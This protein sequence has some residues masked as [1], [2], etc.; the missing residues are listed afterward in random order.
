MMGCN[1][2]A[3]A[4]DYRGPRSFAGADRAR[5]EK[6]L[7]SPERHV[8]DMVLHAFGIDLRGLRRDADR[9]QK[10]DHR[11]VAG[12]AALRH[13]LTGLGQEDTAI[14]L[15]RRQTFAFQPRDGLVGRRMRHAEGAG[16]VGH[17]GFALPGLQ[18]GDQFSIVFEH[19]R[20]ARRAGLIE[21]LGRNRIVRR[22]GDHGHVG[23]MAHPSLL[24]P[25]RCRVF[26]RHGVGRSDTRRQSSRLTSCSQG[27]ITASYVRM[28]VALP[29]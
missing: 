23:F 1:T 27:Y 6:G 5:P 20:G 29:P 19:G 14:G 21:T 9:Q 16:D 4:T 13:G 10:L 26:H 25:P 15:R 17:P 2:I 24:P 22:T 12:A 3:S 11:A 8:R 7:E 28:V 18:V